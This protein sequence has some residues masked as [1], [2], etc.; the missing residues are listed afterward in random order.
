[1][2]ASW[3]SLGKREE[4]MIT[5]ASNA[6]MKNLTKLQ[7][8]TK[9]RNEQGVFICEGKKMFEE[10]ATQKRNHIQKVYLAENYY[11]LYAKENPAYLEG[12]EYEI[13]SD[14]VMKDVSETVTPQGI[15]AI[16]KKPIYQLEDMLRKEQVRLLLLEDIRDPGNLGTMVRTAEGVGMSGI[17]LSKDSVD[18][19]NPKVIRS[20][21]GA[22]FRVPFIYAEDFLESIKKIKE[23]GV[24]I[25]AA[26]LSGAVWYDRVSYLGKTAILIGNEANGLSDQATA[27]SDQRIKIPMEGQVESLNAAIAAAVLMYESY[28]Q[29][30]N[31]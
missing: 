31:V 14:Q 28:R 27:L 8:Q 11:D 25:Y 19:F 23:K 15:L 18:M 2:N 22:I 9:V 17:I 20:T 5:S 12:L 29:I 26:H 4:T 21:M 10:V 7:K 3:A 6:Q 24:S 16:V 30:R 1:M 13:V